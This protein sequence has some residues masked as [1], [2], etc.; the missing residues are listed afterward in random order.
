MKGRENNR[1]NF[2]KICCENFF[3]QMSSHYYEIIFIIE[4][5]DHNIIS[6]NKK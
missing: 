1:N 4:I 2:Q 3:S 5:K 6:L